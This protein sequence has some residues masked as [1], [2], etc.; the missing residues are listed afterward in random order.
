MSKIRQIHTVYIARY[1]DGTYS[2]CE[3][4]AAGNYAPQQQQWNAACQLLRGLGKV[5][6]LRRVV[7]RNDKWEP[8]SKIT[9]ML[10][11]PGSPKELPTSPL[12]A[13]LEEWYNAP[14]GLAKLRQPR[15]ERPWQRGGKPQKGKTKPKE[16]VDE[17]L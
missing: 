4:S 17:R 6:G 7:L 15:P 5:R 9:D 8:F 16:V 10:V 3:I 14:V 2:Y 12:G 13:L 11:K 1:L